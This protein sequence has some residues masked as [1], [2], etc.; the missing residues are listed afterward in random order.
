MLSS[1]RFESASFVNLRAL[2]A[3]DLLSPVLSLRGS[4]DG[5]STHKCLPCGAA[6]GFHHKGEDVGI[7]WVPWILALV[8]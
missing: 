4:E 5:N 1:E 3:W 6:L 7:G 8:L 2:K